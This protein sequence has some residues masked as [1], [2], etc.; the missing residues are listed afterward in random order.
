MPAPC[1]AR[2]C[3]GPATRHQPRGDMNLLDRLST[4]TRRPVAYATVLLAGSAL[5]LVLSIATGMRPAAARSTGSTVPQPAP[6]AGT[7]AVFD[8]VQLGLV[9]G[10]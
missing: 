9:N 2:R 10:A 1:S 8:Q 4:R 7:P 3:T 5:A 6:P